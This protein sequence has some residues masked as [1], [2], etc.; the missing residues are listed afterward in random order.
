[1]GRGEPAPGP[2]IKGN[3]ITGQCIGTNDHLLGKRQ[4]AEIED[5]KPHNIGT[6]YVPT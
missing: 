3:I 1:V 2:Q 6:T 4:V 5:A